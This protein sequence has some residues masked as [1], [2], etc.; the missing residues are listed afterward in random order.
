MGGV[1]SPRRHRGPGRAFWP[2]GARTALLLVPVLLVVLAVAWGAARTAVGLESASHG[3]V[4]LGIVGLSLLPVLLLVLDDLASGGGSVEV[5]SVR[6][7]LTATAA[8][9]PGLVVPRNVVPRAG[10]SL[11]DSAGFEVTGSLRGLRGSD[12]VIVDLEDGH[13]W[14]ET[15][16]LL[17]CA[18]AARLGTPSVVV[19]TAHRQDRAGQF[20]G[21]AR[22]AQLRDRLLE[23]DPALRKAALRAAALA[24]VTR[25]AEAPA[26]GRDR[27]PPSVATLAKDLGL[28]TLRHLTHPMP[29]EELNPYLEEQLLATEVAPHEALP[30]EIDVPRLEQLFQPVLHTHAAER[31]ED[32]ARWLRAALLDEDD[33]IAFTHA[34]RYIG[35]MP[36]PAVARTALLAMLPDGPGPDG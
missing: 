36:G 1:E 35:I 14:W 27:P 18:G 16:L 31:T 26:P 23:A 3:W 7:A 13:A 4:L 30:A 17:L 5:G 32:D 6:I 21:W 28:D 2:F 29:R 19:F 25:L 34:G 8:A 22:P 15:R 20:I 11:A 12:V 24:G 9:R 33:H 10:L